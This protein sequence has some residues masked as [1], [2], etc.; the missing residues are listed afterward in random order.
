MKADQKIEIS[1]RTGPVAVG[2]VFLLVAIV[3]LA[4]TFGGHYRP[5]FI[6][7]DP[8]PVL[9]PRILLALMI[10]L[11]IT[12]IFKSVSS[13]AQRINLAGGLRV[14]GLMAMTTGYIYLIG[15]VGFLIASIP[16]LIAV[17]WMIGYRRVGITLVLAF[18]YSTVVW[19]LFQKV[20]Y[21]ILPSSPWFIF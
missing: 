1:N 11:A 12:V 5:S 20:L 10:V 13:P 18:T 16:F 17:P 21:I 2:V 14:I 8:G 19:L 3:L 6:Q 4:S 7:Y 9:Y 15:Y